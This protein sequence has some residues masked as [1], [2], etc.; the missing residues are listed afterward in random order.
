MDYPEILL[1][2]LAVF[3]VARITRYI[4]EEW[5]GWSEGEPEADS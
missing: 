1:V 4:L 3:V 5:L 2:C